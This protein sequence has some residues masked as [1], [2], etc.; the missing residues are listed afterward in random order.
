[1]R[2]RLLGK[3]ATLRVCTPGDLLIPNYES[4]ASGVFDG[5]FAAAAKDGV[6]RS[7]PRAMG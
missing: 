7:S 3:S 1:M 2:K 5:K 6:I 4:V